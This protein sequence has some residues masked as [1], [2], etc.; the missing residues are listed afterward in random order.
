MIVC[1][2]LAPVAA[3]LTLRRLWHSDTDALAVSYALPLTWGLA[4]AMRKRRLDVLTLLAVVVL[5]CAL[6]ATMASGGSALPLKLRRGAITG[7]LGLACLISVAARRPLLPTLLNLVAS[8]RAGALADRAARIAAAVQG[9]PAAVLTV[10]AGLTLLG[11]AAA[12]VALALSLSTTTFL[13]VAGLARLAVAMTG[14]T[15]AAAYLRVLR[16]RGVHA[17]GSAADSAQT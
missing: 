3:Y 1:G 11:D 2:L 12:Q 15:F 4:V 10:V 17:S 9:K 8:A 13:A 14:A 6:V 5:G 7:P 16:R